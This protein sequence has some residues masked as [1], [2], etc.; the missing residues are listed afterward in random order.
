MSTRRFSQS[1][2]KTGTKDTRFS[3]GFLPVFVD[4]LVVA[5][6]GGAEGSYAGA[7]RGG[8]GAGAGGLR[9]TVDATGGG[10]SLESKFAA[11]PGTA[12]QVTIGGGGTG[13]STYNVSGT[14]G[15]DSVF[16]SITSKGGGKAGPYEGESASG[17]SGGGQARGSATLTGPSGETGQGYKGGDADYVTMRGG[18]GG[19]AGAAGPAASSANAAGVGVSVSISGTATYYAGG[20]G[21]GAC[22][23]S[24]PYTA[25]ARSL[26]GNG[27]G[28]DGGTNSTGAAGTANRGGGGGGASDQNSTNRAGGNGGS[29]II[30]L[31]YPDSYTATFSGGVTSATTSSGGYKISTIT[32]AGT[33]DTITWSAA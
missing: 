1:S 14:Q 10:A 25:V 29:G 12:Y 8:A 22:G 33:A 24:G 21:A 6:G 17:G 15:A 13:G 7:L 9:S 26:G 5:G 20:G 16:S 3:V 11:I 4:Y 27:G 19:G 32:A 2:I 23:T 18:S 31:K 28:G 30:I